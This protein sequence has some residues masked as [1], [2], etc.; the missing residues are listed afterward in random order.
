[1]KAWELLE[2][3]KWIKG[4]YAV[5]ED[6]TPVLVNSEQAIGFCIVGAML[7]CGVYNEHTRDNLLN[8]LGLT[9][10]YWN[11]IYCQSQAEAV[12]LLKKLDI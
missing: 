6:G 11:D 10:E 12:A 5:A 4:H 2:K 8:H 3:S 1:V 7:H 9:I